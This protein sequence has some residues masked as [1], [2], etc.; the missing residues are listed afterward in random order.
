MKLLFPNNCDKW[1]AA[2]STGPVRSMPSEF[3][4]SSGLLPQGAAFPDGGTE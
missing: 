3:M 1:A 2:D 4:T